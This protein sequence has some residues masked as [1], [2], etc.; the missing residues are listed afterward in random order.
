MFTQAVVRVLFWTYERG[1]WQYDVICAVILA[2]IFLTPSTVFDGSAFF[3]DQGSVQE[4]RRAQI[5]QADVSHSTYSTVDFKYL[6][7]E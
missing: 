7:D 3:Q 2:F 5:S 4:E 6:T 1:S